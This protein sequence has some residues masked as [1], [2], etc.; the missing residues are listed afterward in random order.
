MKY[1]YGLII[2]NGLILV[3]E[4]NTWLGMDEGVLTD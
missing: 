4:D 3:A 1:G 2:K